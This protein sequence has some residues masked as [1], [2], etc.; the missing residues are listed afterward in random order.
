MVRFVSAYEA[1]CQ[2][3]RQLD[4]YQ[5]ADPGERRAIDEAIENPELRAY[6]GSRVVP[7]LTLHE[8][9]LLALAN[10]PAFQGRTGIEQRK[11]MGYVAS[12]KF[13]G[14]VNGLENEILN[15]GKGTLF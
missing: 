7:Q 8:S 13:E 6:F 10:S 11:V 9:L 3:T 14:A 15:F 4:S 1:F 12:Q 2:Y 5:K